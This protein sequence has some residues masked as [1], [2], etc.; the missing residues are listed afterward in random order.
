MNHTDV[1]DSN[2]TQPS[3]LRFF[4]R[5]LLVPQSHRRLHWLAEPMEGGT[6][7]EELAGA[8]RPR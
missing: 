6:S 1:S 2:T 3:L 4:A 7:F 5:E 8:G